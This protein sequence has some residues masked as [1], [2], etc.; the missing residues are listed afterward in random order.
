MP[1]GRLV[2]D[3]SVLRFGL[4][5]E[6]K[7][8]GTHLHGARHAIPGV[9]HRELPI[10]VKA[11]DLADEK[12]ILMQTVFSSLVFRRLERS[13]LADQSVEY[14]LRRLNTPLQYCE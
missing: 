5:N 9:V 12:G 8:V 13:I 4:V 14:A 3:R 2:N 11:A 10:S 1:K 7:V 6:G